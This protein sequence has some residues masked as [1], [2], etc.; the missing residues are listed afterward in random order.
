MFCPYC[1]SV[2][3]NDSGVCPNCSYVV[4]IKP[5]VDE[6]TKKKMVFSDLKTL[7]SSPLY[8]M[9]VLVSVIY[10]A[11]F[12]STWAFDGVG[13]YDIKTFEEAFPDLTYYGYIRY[14]YYFLSAV[15]LV[16]IIT[17]ILRVVASFL[18]YSSATSDEKESISVKGI[19]LLKVTYFLS[20]ACIVIPILVFFACSFTPI[21]RVNLLMGDFTFLN[22]LELALTAVLNT[23]YTVFYVIWLGKLK[24]SAT[25]GK[26]N[27]FIPLFVL[28]ISFANAAGNISPIVFVFGEGW[29]GCISSVFIG[30]SHL[31]VAL[32]ILKYHSM[33]SK[34]E[35]I[36]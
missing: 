11:L 9:L 22:I 7:F 6:A 14:I 19:S 26:A 1:G 15:N 21:A 32:I 3:A 13:L 18:L 23:L 4:Q 28:M 35:K 36:K 29:L 16:Y 25:T 5:V 27:S 31:L 17:L 33:M 10:I 34:L 24:D 2:I 8:L 12:V 30:I 20:L